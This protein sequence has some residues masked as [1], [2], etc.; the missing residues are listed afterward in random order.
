[1]GFSRQE[2]WSGLP[3]PPWGDLPDPGIE[4]RS[5]HIAGRFFTIWVT[6]EALFKGKLPSHAILTLQGH[7]AGQRKCSWPECLC[8]GHR[9]ILI[10]TSHLT[11]GEPDAKG[12]QPGCSGQG[13]GW[14]G[15]NRW[16]WAVITV[17]NLSYIYHLMNL[18]E[19]LVLK[20]KLTG[21]FNCQVRRQQKME[22]PHIDQWKRITLWEAKLAGRDRRQKV[23]T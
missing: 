11:L 19:P 17:P 10:L 7:P 2:Y 12:H 14:G 23:L 21:I 8:F 16:I 13:L 6:R 5:P 15:W 9:F 1:M 22:T 4:P 20:D 3:C 18:I